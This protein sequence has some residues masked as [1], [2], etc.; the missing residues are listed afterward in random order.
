MWLYA[1]PS[2]KV[3][4]SPSPFFLLGLSNHGVYSFHLTKTGFISTDVTELSYHK[5]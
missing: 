2:F 4:V 1:T 5:Q 3:T